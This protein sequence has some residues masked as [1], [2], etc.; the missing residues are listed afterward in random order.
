MKITFYVNAMVLLESANSRVLCDPWV[1]FDDQSMSGFY[2][3]PRSTLTREEVAA[4]KPDFIY[5]THTHPDHFDPPTLKLFNR[6]I[7][8]LVS[9][10]EHNFSA[11]E[12][13]R[14]GFTDV[15]VAVPGEGLPLNGE[16]HC[17][18]EPSARHPEIDSI[19]VFRL[20]RYTALNANDNVFDR[21][22]CARLR[23]RAGRIDVGLLPSGAHGPWPMFFDNFTDEEKAKHA[24]ERAAAQ[25]ETFT[26][27]VEAVQPRY[28]VPI[29]A[30]LVAGGDKALQ[31]HY[32]GIRPR[33]EVLA[34]ARRKL[35][36][37]PVLLSERCNF[38]VATGARQGDYVE[39]TYD[40][41]REYLQRLAAKPNA[42]SREGLFYVAP[43]ERIDLTR[44]LTLARQTQ[45][46]WQ[47]TKGVQSK[48]VYCF[49]VGDDCLYRLT[50]AD[51]RVTRVQESQM[52]DEAYEIFRLPYELLLGILTRHY[53]W[54]NVKTQ[55][56]R[57]HRKGD[58]VDHELMVMM[59]YLQI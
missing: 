55:Y 18:I 34:H 6:D 19:A 10:Y 4:I 3:F 33:S 46:R 12:L 9:Y 40:S 26:Q 16:D 54:S 47:Q 39:A 31:Y 28:V 17:W 13:R 32:S 23:E 45:H 43:S 35:D 27:Y 20:G 15:R 58:Q 57:Y 42:F 49:D 29:A 56:V 51:D 2:N 5:V 25:K 8:I 1:T 7:P 24:A 21:D 11:R 50:L 37:E 48:A 38:D 59:S 52:M 41:E 14:V 22:Q 36:F 30:G 53:N 44:L